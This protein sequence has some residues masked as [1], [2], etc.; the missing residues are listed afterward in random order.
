MGGCGLFWLNDE[1]VS[2]KG[3]IL[4]TNRESS[5]DH[6]QRGGKVNDE[7]IGPFATTGPMMTHG[8]GDDNVRKC[9]KTGS[10]SEKG[11]EGSDKKIN[12]RCVI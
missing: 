7:I 3:H 8:G 2:C 5:R 6:N 4:Y 9:D 10:D 12:S 11:N 1:K